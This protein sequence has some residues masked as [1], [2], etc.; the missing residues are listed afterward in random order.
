MNG[1]GAT[2]ASAL[3]PG[4]GN[5]PH[6]RA[7]P[8][9]QPC[10]PGQAHTLYPAF[11]P[12]EN[13]GKEWALRLPGGCAP[14]PAVWLE[15]AGTGLGSTLGALAPGWSASQDQAGKCAGIG[16]EHTTTGLG[17]MPGSG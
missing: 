5:S 15:R 4:K 13:M 3:S 10:S 6:R 9:E 7:T 14:S 17:S 11:L 12:K 8:L 16:L 1:E 2:Y